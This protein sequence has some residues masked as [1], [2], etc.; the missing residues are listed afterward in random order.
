MRSLAPSEFSNSVPGVPAI[1]DD[2]HLL[3]V[4]TVNTS[5]VLFVNSGH[6]EEEKLKSWL[7]LCTLNGLFN[8]I[9]D[10]GIFHVFAIEATEDNNFLLINVGYSKTLTS[11]KLFLRQLNELPLI[12]GNV[13]ELF[14]G[15]NVLFR[16]I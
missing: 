9:K 11:R 8:A 12:L 4:D 2:L 13:V 1:L 15:V 3:P 10:M 7:M 5:S 14:N 6:L 16:G